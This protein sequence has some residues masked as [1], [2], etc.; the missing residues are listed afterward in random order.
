MKAREEWKKA[1]RL[2]R[3][4]ILLYGLLALGLWVHIVLLICGVEY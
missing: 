3:I 4:D 2:K 1:S